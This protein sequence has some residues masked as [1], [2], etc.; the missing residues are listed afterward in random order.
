MAQ[1]SGGRAGIRRGNPKFWPG[2]GKLGHLK[3]EG[4]SFHQG[5]AV[6]EDPLQELSDLPYG[7][8]RG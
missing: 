5:S 2:D 4:F 1:R 6:M 3:L 8:Y 7:V